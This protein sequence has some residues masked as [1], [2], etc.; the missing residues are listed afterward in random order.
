MALRV[1]SCPAV[2]PYS[3]TWRNLTSPKHFSPPRAI[4]WLWTSIFLWAER[5]NYSRAIWGNTTE[6]EA[7]QT[8]MEQLQKTA[9]RIQHE[10]QSSIK[11]SNR[12]LKFVLVTFGQSRPSSEKQFI[13]PGKHKRISST[14]FPASGAGNISEPR[15]TPCVGRVP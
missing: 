2:L 1:S 3:N 9:E 14:K 8:E 10:T 12:V 6:E 11:Y 5:L 15:L 7:W 13:Y 4:M